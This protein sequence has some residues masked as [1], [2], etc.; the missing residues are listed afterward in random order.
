MQVSTQYNEY[1]SLDHLIDAL[2]T[3]QSFR[4]TNI[5]N[6]FKNAVLMLIW[7][8]LNPAVNYSQSA[9][10]SRAICCSSAAFG[11]IKKQLCPVYGTH[12]C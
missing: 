10:N 4:M 1:E 3:G 2:A 8:D 12:T 11:A 5:M 9:I 7:H 6:N